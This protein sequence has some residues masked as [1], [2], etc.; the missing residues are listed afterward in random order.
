ML[1]STKDRGQRQIKKREFRYGS[2][3]IKTEKGSK[4]ELHHHENGS[5]LE[6]K[7]RCI[8]PDNFPAAGSD[9]RTRNHEK[10]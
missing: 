7:R 6:R 4:A 8:E 1:K 3:N 5:D 9:R 2:P 10:G